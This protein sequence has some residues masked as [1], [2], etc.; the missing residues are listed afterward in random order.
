[1]CN[2][3]DQKGG[4]S[5]ANQHQPIVD[6]LI[7]LLKDNPD[8]K[9]ALEASLQKANRMNVQTLPEYYN[10]IDEMVTLIPTTRNLLPNALEFYYLIDNSPDG[11]LQKNKL[12]SDWNHKFIDDWGKF[13]GTP[14]SAAGLATFY[15]D[16]TYHIEDYYE[17]P[18]GWL[19][20]NQ[21]FARDFRPGKRPIAGLC[22]DG[23][24]VAPADSKY[25]GSWEI[26]E[27]AEITVKGITWSVLELMDGSPYQDRFRGGTFMHSYLSAHDYHRFH[28][29]VR[30]IV[31][32]SRVITGDV[33][34]DVVM[35]DDGS[36][37]MVD[38]TGYQFTQER[39]LI[40]MESPI[41]LVAILPIGMGQV[42]S[43]TMTADVGVELHKGE[44]FG[45]F[46]FGGSD[47][48][49]LFEPG[50]VKIT[51]EIDTHYKVGEAIARVIR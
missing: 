4:D 41:G 20:F 44:E 39:G 50:K 11:F 51:A 5:S 6:E 27:D 23:I 45:F 37:D 43:V 8:I 7:T 42:S 46:Q 17:G 49:I 38:G 48:I 31:K 35:N 3:P 12:F 26:T 10:Y 15:T 1:M 13:L 25:H 9:D 30:G 34:L 22:D 28:V 40:V 24:I 32:E 36:L 47:I 2:Q 19:T 16:P 29:P 21:F 18:S 14:E 33:V